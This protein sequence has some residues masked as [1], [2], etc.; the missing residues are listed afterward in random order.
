MGG[1]MS[2][3]G[4]ILDFGFPIFYFRLWGRVIGDSLGEILYGSSIVRNVALQ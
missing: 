3:L 1:M 2:T 4:G